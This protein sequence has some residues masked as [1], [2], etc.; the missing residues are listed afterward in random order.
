MSSL[1]VSLTVS[2]P[3]CLVRPCL[4]ETVSST[5]AALGGGGAGGGFE[6]LHFLLASALDYWQGAPE[7]TPRFLKDFDA[8][9]PFDS[10]P[11]YAVLHES[12]YS[13]GPATRWAAQRVREQQ[14]DKAF[15]AEVR[16]PLLS[17]LLGAA[18]CQGL[19]C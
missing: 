2:F 3:T 13:Q 19:W 16:V 18:A 6:R 7:L 15:D 1:P 9:L 12:I 5:R 4:R 11:L 17:R 10:N 8:W 14:F